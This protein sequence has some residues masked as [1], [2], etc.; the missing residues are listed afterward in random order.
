MG[1]SRP[2]ICK[3][4]ML[5]PFLV[6]SCFQDFT[7]KSWCGWSK[8]R[9]KEQRRNTQVMSLGALS[10]LRGVNAWGADGWGLNPV[11]VQWM[12]GDRA[13]QSAEMAPGS[14][15]VN[16][17][18]DTRIKRLCL[19]KFLCTAQTPNTTTSGAGS[20]AASA[21]PRCRPTPQP[22]SHPSEQ[23]RPPRSL[24]PITSQAV[25]KSCSTANT[26]LTGEEGQGAP[27]TTPQVLPSRPLLL[28]LSSL[29]R[30]EESPLLS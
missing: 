11:S 9:K 20:R 21:A 13:K 26:H 14:L 1:A 17:T 12:N 7:W 2:K 29:I 27:I 15:R 6:C 19:A 10:R 23:L 18:G 28:I 16:K 5:C 30:A 8:V 24:H 4:C 22:L 25:V 3:Y